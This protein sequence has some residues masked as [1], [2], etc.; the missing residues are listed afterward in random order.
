MSF[1]ESS[2]LLLDNPPAPIAASRAG[3]LARG[4]ARGSLVARAAAPLA[5]LA[6]RAIPVLGAINLALSAWD[7]WN[8]FHGTDE[9]FPPVTVPFPPL[10]AGLSWQV[11]AKW[12]AQPNGNFP[13]PPLVVDLPWVAIAGRPVSFGLVQV[14]DPLVWRIRAQLDDGSV[15]NDD[16]VGGANQSVY[17][18]PVM[19]R[20]EFRSVDP[21][22]PAYPYPVPL[23]P[24]LLPGDGRVPIL[25]EIPSTPGGFPY[26]VQIPGYLENPGELG[27]RPVPV[28]YDP[29]LPEQQ[30][31]G[32]PQAW[33]TPQGVQL[34]RGSQGDPIQ[35]DGDAIGA[36]S[37]LLDLA[38]DYRQR[39]P[40]AV[41]TCTDGGEPPGDCCDCEDIRAIVYE[42]L[43][44]KFPPK[45]P[46]ERRQV[47]FS[48][49]NSGEF[50]LPEFTE[51]IEL[52]I[53]NPPLNQKG[54]AGGALAPPVRYNG[55]YSFGATTSTSERI[56]IHYDK[57]SIPVP[58]N[59]TGFS[60]TIYLEG[61]AK[62]TASYIL[63]APG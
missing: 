17:K 36:L 47:S 28:I 39:V 49:S 1:Y 42:E 51:W 10:P 6:P 38:S 20:I 61:T 33:I 3:M 18:V 14:G 7:A 32:L 58:P 34:G 25:I 31:R 41:T 15:V 2:L 9:P 52:E 11:R 19:E 21:E 12:S 53:V 29:S 62:V 5:F 37:D 44:N 48:A 30:R 45:R 60:Y 63:P 56:P 22:S 55:W 13:V 26:P 8:A 50:V 59:V 24:A 35:I 23:T 57:I 54:Q 16:A 40:P 4:I 43:D 46:S 27:D